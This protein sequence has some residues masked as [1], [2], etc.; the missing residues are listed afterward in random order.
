MNDHE[1]DIETIDRYLAGDL[2]PVEREA[3]EKRL[4]DDE[5]LTEQLAHTRLAIEGI[6]ANAVRERIKLLHENYLENRTRNLYRYI[7]GIAAS[8]IVL[9]LASY[10]LIFRNQSQQAKNFYA[11]FAPYP[12]PV[13]VR[14]EGSN[15]HQLAMVYYQREEFSKAVE[16]FKRI[17]P[18]VYTQE[19]KF[20]FG[21]SLLG[22]KQ[23][24]EA[25]VI[26]EEL[27]SNSTHYDE[28]V[29][30]YLAL[31]YL[32]SG[33]HE[34]AKSLLLQIEKGDYQFD[35]AQELLSELR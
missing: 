2:N 32:E 10:F 3:F 12:S 23:P 16:A 14:G 13:N 24:G 15:D 17:G 33:E 21:V 35:S 31:S 5:A 20:Y 34:K 11:Y 7:S 6:Q 8:L 26:F 4:L 22:N 9:V 30:W 28:P 18:A 27:R 19:I 1:N 29:R 25:S